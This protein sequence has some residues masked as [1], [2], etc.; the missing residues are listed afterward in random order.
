[1]DKTSGITFVEIAF[2]VALAALLALFFV[3]KYKQ[4]RTS[5]KERLD[6]SNHHKP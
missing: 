3:K 6:D 2:Y 1:M 5:E 4:V